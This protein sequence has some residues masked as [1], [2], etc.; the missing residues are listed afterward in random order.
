MNLAHIQAHDWE[1]FKEIHPAAYQFLLS[2]S[3]WNEYWH[4][5]TRTVENNVWE[6][7]R[8][9]ELEEHFNGGKI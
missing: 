7:A 2:R 1:V 6:K 5:K 8:L 4:Y 9:A 3:L